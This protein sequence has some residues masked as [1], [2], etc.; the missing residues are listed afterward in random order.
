MKKYG[1]AILAVLVVA[2]CTLPL[3]AQEESQQSPRG[4]RGGGMQRFRERQM[5]AIAAIEGELE[6][7]K[8]PPEGLPGSREAWQDLSEEE[9]TQMRERF[10]QMREERIKS[11]DIIEDQLARLKGPRALTTEHDEAIEALKALQK[12]ATEEKAEKTAS[13]I[14]KMIEEKNKAFEEKMAKLGMEP[15]RGGFGGR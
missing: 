2:A 4:P 14:E 12:T 9:R 3:L 11:I 8:T 13:A 7:M 5:E 15:R 6:K 1:I 10:R